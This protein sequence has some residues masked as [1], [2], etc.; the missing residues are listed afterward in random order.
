MLIKIFIKIK[1]Q[2]NILRADYSEA[3]FKQIEFAIVK[4]GFGIVQDC[5]EHGIKLIGITYGMNKEFQLNAKKL[6]DYNLLKKL[7]QFQTQFYLLKM[8]ISIN[9]IN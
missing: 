7:N 5:L 8:K 1:T 4:P 6:Q 9:S 2:S 3:M